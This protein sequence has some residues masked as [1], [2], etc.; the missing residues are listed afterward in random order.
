M[1]YERDYQSAT[2]DAIDK[3]VLSRLKIDENNTYEALRTKVK[4]RVTYISKNLPVKFTYAPKFI[5]NTV[6]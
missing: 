3:K 1:T 2:P 6:V 4:L 5:Y